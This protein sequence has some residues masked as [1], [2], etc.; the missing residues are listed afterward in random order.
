[1]DSELL[2]KKVEKMYNYLC[3]EAQSKN[4]SLPFYRELVTF[5]NYFIL[6]KYKDEVYHKIAFRENLS[7]FYKKLVDH[8]DTFKYFSQ[9]KINII[10]DIFNQDNPFDID[11][12]IN[13]FKERKKTHNI[14]FKS[15]PVL[16]R[17][18]SDIFD[19]LEWS[20]VEIARQLTLIS[21]QLFSKIEYKEILTG[22][23]SKKDKHILAPN[24]MK[25]IDRSNKLSYWVIEEILS[26]DKKLK[27]AAAIEKFLLT[28]KECCKLC[29]FNDCYSIYLS[30]EN[31][32]IKNLK[33]T[34][35]VMNS[36]TKNLFE[37]LK[38]FCS[39]NSNY[40]NMRNEMKNC[41]GRAFIPFL[42]VMLRELGFIEEDPKYI[43]DNYLLNIEKIQKVSNVIDFY[44]EF[45]NATL[46]F[47]RVEELSILSDLHPKS[48][49]ELEIL[50]NKI[51]KF[52]FFIFRACLYIE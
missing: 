46:L 10:K 24:V 16:P 2:F 26:Y 13:Q 14:T 35:N 39:Y 19:V 37:Y 41:K 3:S 21:N 43:K 31:L 32:L 36:E 17:K 30:I 12:L 48:Y 1:M 47:R 45:K 44:F 33:K 50:A 29:N 23:W 40:R 7:N 18:I 27:R 6:L 49:T 28:A 20:E 8:Q 34:W 51:G 38:E 42:G 22:N 5:M 15:E 9:L 4:Q 11:Y 52:N 25:I